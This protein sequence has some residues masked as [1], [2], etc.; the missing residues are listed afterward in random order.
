MN[1]IPK[2]C[3]FAPGSNKDSARFSSRTTP[4][5]PRSSSKKYVRQK[6]QTSFLC[7]NKEIPIENPAATPSK[8]KNDL[9]PPPPPVFNVGVASQPSQANPE[10]HISKKRKSGPLPQVSKPANTTSVHHLY[11]KHGYTHATEAECTEWVGAE[12]IENSEAVSKC[13]AEGFIRQASHLRELRSVVSTNERLVKEVK[14][15]KAK[16]EEEKNLLMENYK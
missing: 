9:P 10:Q 5:L 12:L 14:S 3:Q 1:N 4:N 7:K 2:C 13:L 16:A 8:K 15:L 11:A 6:S